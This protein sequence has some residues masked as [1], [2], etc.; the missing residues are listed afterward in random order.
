MSQHL[1]SLMC[2][3]SHQLTPPLIRKLCYKTNSPEAVQTLT[4]LTIWRPTIFDLPLRHVISI[5][6]LEVLL[7][8]CCFF[9]I[10][11]NERQ[12]RSSAFVC[13]YGKW[14]S[15]TCSEREN[16]GCKLQSVIMINWLSVLTDFR[17]RAQVNEGPGQATF[18]INNEDHTLGNVLR[19]MA[20]QE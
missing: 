4:I 1:V 17:N 15:A 11:E 12:A 9:D 3:R 5:D 8:L 6:C 19:M 14:E 13:L 10:I 16:I 7:L 2:S 20:M 18:E